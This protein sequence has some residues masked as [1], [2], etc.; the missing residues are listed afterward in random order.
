MRE[1]EDGKPAGLR[2]VLVDDPSWLED[3]AEAL[4][5]QAQG[6]LRE[7]YSWVRDLE[8][9][10]P[11]WRLHEVGSFEFAL[12]RKRVAQ[13]KICLVSL[14]GIYRRG[15]KPFNISPGLV[16]PHLRAMQ[17][18]ARGDWTMREISVDCD[19]ADLAI[20][21][22]HYDHSD[23]DEDINCVF[24]L[25]RLRELEI[26]EFIGGCADVH[27]AL[28]GYAPDVTPLLATAACEIVS[29]LRS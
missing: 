3:D 16:P 25:A 14:A 26:E 15:Q 18:R 4:T 1:R 8:S 17:F 23:G 12:P 11:G 21:H 24:P 19:M 7:G 28:M 27:Y 20:A 2:R 10:Y 9:R 13:S 5:T 29:R 6:T 22:A